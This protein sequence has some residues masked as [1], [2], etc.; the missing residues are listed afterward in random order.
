MSTD[1]Y[2]ADTEPR[3]SGGSGCLKGCL[4]ALVIILILGAL[5]AWWVSS[6]WRGWV[7]SGAAEG[8]NQI[9]D[10]SDL[11]PAEKEELKAESKRVTDGIADGS[12][13]LEQMGQIMTGIV[14]SP[15]MPMFMVKAVEA[16]Y[17]EKS[18]L[19]D[20]EKSE[21]H[22]TLERYASGLVS[23]QIPQES[24]DQVLVHIADK[25]A[26]GEWKMREQVSDEDLRKFL[27]AAKEQADAANIPEEVEPIDPSE[28]LR[29][30]IDK[31]LGPAPA[32]P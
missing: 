21:A 2:E 13:S 5:T 14:E 17:V 22:V 4:I 27:A 23:K 8:I 10:D 12:I 3:K 9:I 30:V 16:Q 11:P 1:T 32:A 19:S 29:K 18:G 15:L 31:V 20:E 24:V 7:S 6:N 26:N 25:D 28:E